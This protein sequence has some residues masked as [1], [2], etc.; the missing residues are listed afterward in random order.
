MYIT[1]PRLAVGAL[2]IEKIKAS[3]VEACINGK[4]HECLMAHV[5]WDQVD[6]AKEI[7]IRHGM[8]TVLMIKLSD[9]QDTLIDGFRVVELG[10]KHGI[11]VYDRSIEQYKLTHSAVYVGHTDYVCMVPE[12]YYYG[13]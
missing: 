6:V 11:E 1:L 4:I 9:D 3:P 7:A 2:A 12:S 13:V 8:Q 10:L 5:E